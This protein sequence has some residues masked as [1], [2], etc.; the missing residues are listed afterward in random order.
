MGCTFC[1]CFSFGN[2]KAPH[3]RAVC[4][5]LLA[6]GITHRFKVCEV[7]LARNGWCG[8]PS[9][10]RA[11]CRAPLRISL[12][13]QGVPA[14]LMA[15]AT[16]HWLRGRSRTGFRGYE[17][18]VGPFYYPALLVRGFHPLLP[19]ASADEHRLS[20]P[21]RQFTAWRP[22]AQHMG[23]AVNHTARVDGGR[24]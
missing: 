7:A 9:D 24:R 15:P 16:G 12:P 20:A 17:P 18:R 13:C 8:V 4:G 10:R 22:E 5:G 6:G 23:N 3:C 11:R 19:M 2:E 1:M 21:V 14:Y